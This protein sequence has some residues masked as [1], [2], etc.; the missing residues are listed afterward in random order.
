M[1]IV[2]CFYVDDF[3]VLMLKSYDLVKKKMR[4]MVL[5]EVFS[6]VLCNRFISQGLVSKVKDRR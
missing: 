3:W 5:R 1:W 6:R 4:W 2:G